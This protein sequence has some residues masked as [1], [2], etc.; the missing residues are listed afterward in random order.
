[1]RQGITGRCEILYPVRRTDRLCGCWSA[2]ATRCS[3]YPRLVSFALAAH[4]RRRL[5]RSGCHLWMG[6]SRRSSDYRALHDFFRIHH[7]L[8]VH[9]CLGCC[10]GRA[11]HVCTA[12]CSRAA[13]AVATKLHTI[14]SFASARHK[15]IAG[16]CC[17]ATFQQA[18]RRFEFSKVNQGYQ[19]NF[20]NAAIPLQSGQTVVALLR[21]G[22][23]QDAGA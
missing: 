22:F 3:S 2:T 10:A 7:L 9:R 8:R 5:R 18:A 1:M 4:G 6:P 21:R 11:I 13:E 19:S 17:T 12:D 15:I 20:F 23:A 16:L 14:G